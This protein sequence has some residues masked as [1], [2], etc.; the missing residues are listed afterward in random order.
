MYTLKIAD[1]DIALGG[2]G[3][4]VTVTGAER[5]SQDLSCWLLEPV[6]SDPMYRK[7]GSRLWSMI[8]EP[9][10]S[11]TTASV[12]SETSRVV[13]NYVSYQ[14]SQFNSSGTTQAER[15]TGIWGRDDLVSSV[16]EVSA[17][18]SFDAIDVRVG[19]VTASGRAVDLNQTL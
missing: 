3:V 12:K 8:G 14:S 1:G 13:G 11:G 4:P 18:Q 2:D 17:T 15:L 9:I 7:F 6:G 5:I 19:L 16:S 10:L